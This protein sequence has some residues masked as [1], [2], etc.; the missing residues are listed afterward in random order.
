MHGLLGSFSTRRNVIAVLFLAIAL[1][2]VLGVSYEFYLKTWLVDSA[3]HFLFGVALGLIWLE[4]AQRKGSIVEPMATIGFVLFVSLAWELFEL[5]LWTW[6]SN[7]S[8]ALMLHSPSV[9]DALTDMIAA[10]IGG[11]IIAFQ[12]KPKT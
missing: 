1:L 5:L 11:T 10:L 6:L 12:L 9:E 2:Y 8:G 4:L 3:Q 7:Y